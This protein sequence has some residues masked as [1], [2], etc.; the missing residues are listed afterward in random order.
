MIN[1]KYFYRWG[2]AFG[3]I[4]I[5]CTCTSQKYIQEIPYNF[6][7]DEFNKSSYGLKNSVDAQY[8]D[9]DDNLEQLTDEELRVKEKY[10]I[11]MEVMP[12]EVTNYKL[13]SYIDRW[14]GTPYKKQSLDEKIGVDCS[15][16]MQSL[17]SD[18]YGETFQKTPDGIFRAKSIQLFT[19][20]TFLKEGDILFFR[21]DKEHPISD[22]GMYLHN[23]RILACTEKGLN[24]Y[25]FNDEYFQLRYVAAGR[26]K[27]KN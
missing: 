3:L 21:Y 18:V 1:F 14:V 27:P 6:S 9:L 23:D 11:I 5:L 4:L 17:F 10:S 13:Y 22:V 2:T 16:F 7:S 19:G 15:Y 8:S 12:K 25:N 20:R 24:I 26:L